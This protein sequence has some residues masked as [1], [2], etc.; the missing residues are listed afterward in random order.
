MKIAILHGSN[1]GFFPRYYKN[2]RSAIIENGDT[3]QL[4]VPNSRINN[5]T[6]LPNQTIWASR[7]N[8]HI[9]NILYQITGRRDCW[10]FFSTID[11]LRKLKHFHP[12][13]I[14]L[15]VINQGILNIPMFVRYLNKQHIPVV[16]TFHDCRV[17]TGGCPYFDE[18]KCEAWQNGCTNC[19]LKIQAGNYSVGDTAWQW[20]FNKRWINKIENLS[21]VTPSQ[22]LADFVKQSFLKDKTIRVI[23]N[24]VE[25]SSF[26]TLSNFDVYTT[27]NI[28][29]N[30]K[31]VLGCAINWEERKGMSTFEH[32]SKTLTNE[33]KIVLVGGISSDKKKELCSKGILCTGR[34]KT[35]EEMVAWYQNAVV[36]VNPTFADNFP[37]T[38]IEA[39]ASGTPVITYNTGG[40]PEA[41]DQKTG[42]VVKQG[43]EVELIN[44]I[45]LVSNH[46][47]L[48]QRELCLARS[49]MFSCRN[50][51]AYTKLFH[52]ILA[53]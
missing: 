33:Y 16:W 39:L 23:Y 3:V 13:I 27:Y 35:F 49:E 15:N 32:I 5:N 6:I 44:A 29:K 12:D 46:T 22:W 20:K 7:I 14:H 8:W 30:K 17:F 53:K 9:H 36:F 42:I 37:T 26:S 40:S 34:T 48:Y 10:S 19:P 4:F 31:I 21:I 43:D 11:L 25:T 24:G 2:I 47:N 50:Y 38:N 51:Q 18:I 52:S 41:L 28:D 45:Y 1:Q